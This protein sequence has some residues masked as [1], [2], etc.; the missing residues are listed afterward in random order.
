MTDDLHQKI[1]NALDSVGNLVSVCVRVGGF[2]AV[3]RPSLG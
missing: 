2:G 1:V 3:A